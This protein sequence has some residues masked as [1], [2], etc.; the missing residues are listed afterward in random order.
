MPHPEQISGGIFMRKRI[1]AMMI[2][3]IMVIGMLPVS[4]FAAETITVNAPIDITANTVYQNKTFVRASGYTGTFFNVTSG[5]LTLEN[6]VVDAGAAWTMDTE[7]L[8]AWVTAIEGGGKAVVDIPALVNLPSGAVTSTASLIN[9]SGTGNLSLVNSTVE[10]MYAASASI[11][12]IRVDSVDV[13]KIVFNGATIRNIASPTSSAIASGS[14]CD[15]MEIKGSTKFYNNIATNPGGLI[16][17]CGTADTMNDTVITIDGTTEIYDNVILNG[18][19]IMVRRATGN[20]N[21][22]NIHDNYCLY[23]G[24]NLNCTPLYLHDHSVFNMNG[25]EISENYGYRGNAIVVNA[26]EAQNSEV[27]LNAGTIGEGKESKY[28]SGSVVAHT[29]PIT[30]GENM[31]VSDGILANGTV[32]NNGEITGDVVAYSGVT[33]NGTINGDIVSASEIT[34]TGTVTGDAVALTPDVTIDNTGDIAGDIQIGTGDSAEKVVALVDGAAFTDI[35]DALKAV[36]ENSIVNILSD[37]T[38]D[39]DW[40]ARFTGAKIYVPVTINGNG[41]TLK[42]TN[43]VYDAGN[44]LAAFRFE[45]PATVKNLTIDMSEAESGWGTRIRAISTKANLAVDNCTFIGNGSENNNRAIIFGEGS[46]AAIGNLEV[47]ITNSVFK[48]W[49]RGLGDNENGQDAKSVTVIGNTFDDADVRISAADGITFSDNTMTDS[50]VELRTHSKSASLE[51]A[52]T[53]NSGSPII[54]ID[55]PKT[56]VIIDDAE[57]NVIVVFTD[58]DYAEENAQIGRPYYLNYGTANQQMFIKTASGEIVSAVT[59]TF[60]NADDIAPIIVKVGEK[61]VAPEAP[62]KYRHVFDGWYLDSACTDRFSFDTVLFADV[63]LYAKW[64]EDTELNGRL[65]MIALTTSLFRN[66]SVNAKANEGGTLTNEGIVFTMFNN[67]LKYK[68]TPDEGYEVVSFI[69][70]GVDL[71]PITEYTLETI[72]ANHTIEVVFAPIA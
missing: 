63:V 68:A 3:V 61:A 56:T 48:D 29:A 21:A 4:V 14:S 34:N 12:A 2:A 1:F 57:S 33:N 62:T 11:H 71:G 16:Q 69:V 28:I 24:S 25:G 65:A 35:K 36:K 40:D 17:F 10:N 64:V 72:M 54:V 26:T 31:A 51:I 18:S 50:G 7:Q 30:V 59:V 58:K 46:G 32:E 8:N 55:P 15:S 13:N 6:C 41:N 70:D 27:N 53:D 66:Y 9:V 43:T 60:M 52:A 38:I 39:Y 44:H 19:V 49:R 22:G 42:F 23:T 67:P 45:A 5:T 20:L 37:I 47:S